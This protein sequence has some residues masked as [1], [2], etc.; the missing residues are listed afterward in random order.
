M[1][2]DELRKFADDLYE[3]RGNVPP[4]AR[5]LNAAA[6]AWGDLEGRMFDVLVERDTLRA[7]IEELETK[8]AM[9]EMALRVARMPLPP[10]EAALAG[11]Q[12]DLTLPRT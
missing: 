12:S 2:P 5:R 3:L 10:Y 7:R 6:D 8:L 4:H 9:A 11:K 1:N